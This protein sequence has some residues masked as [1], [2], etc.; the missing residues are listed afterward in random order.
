MPELPEVET[1]RSALHARLAGRRL[2][3]VDLRRRDLR[4]PFPPRFAARLA[5]RR[6]ERLDRRGKYLLWRFEGGLVMLAH[7]GMS[8]RLLLRG[9][10]DGA[11]PEPAPHEHAVLRFEDGA[12]VALRDPR[13]FGLM[14]L[15]EEAELPAHPMLAEMGPEPLEDGFDAAYVAAAFRGRA[16]S[17][18]AALLDQRLVAGLGNIYACESLYRAGILPTRPAGSLRAPRTVRLVAAVRSVL[19]DAIE[20]GGS[21]LRDYTQASGELGYFQH[22]WSVYGRAAAPCTDCHPGARCRV[23][24]STQG[25]RST[26]WCPR[27]QR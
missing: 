16:V 22:Q 9:A 15:A 13:R 6:L 24:R 17:V 21:S 25:G 14:T 5:G 23:R 12:S 27:R 11:A 26:F 3:S 19:R 2:A 7:L 8:G 4:I 18:K 10:E 20:A 1:I